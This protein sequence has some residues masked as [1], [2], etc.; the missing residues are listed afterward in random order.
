MGE[1]KKSDDRSHASNLLYALTQVSDTLYYYYSC[2]SMIRI[3]VSCRQL[4]RP[5]LLLLPSWR[6]RRGVHNTTGEWR[7][8]Q[9][10]RLLLQQQQKF[11]PAQEVMIASD[12]DDDDDDLQPMWKDMERR[13]T[14]RKP[15]TIQQAG[16]NVGRRNVR[17]TDEEAWLQA[18]LYDNEKD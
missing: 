4:S 7:K 1:K 17:P 13:V 18:G 6:R 14:R 3:A 16:P 8:H 2:K 5:C 11:Q 12:D 15:V 9:L 10:D